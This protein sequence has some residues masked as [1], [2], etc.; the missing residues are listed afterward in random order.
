MCIDY[1]QPKK[2]T[3][4][5]KY[6]LPR[7]DDWF[8]QLQGDK[9]FSKIDLRLGYHQVQVWEKDILKIAFRT[10]YGHFEFLVM[11]FGL[12]NA[13]VVF[14]DLNNRIFRPSLDMFVITFIDD[15]LV[16]SRHIVS[17]TGIMVDTQNIEV[18]KTCPRPTTPSQHTFEEL[19][20]RFTSA[21][22][23]VLIEGYAVYC[24]TS[25][26]QQQI[27][28]KAHHSYYSI[29]PGLTKM[30]HDIKEIYWWHEMKRDIGEFVAHCPN[31]Q[32]VKVEH[33]KP[34]GLVQEIPIPVRKW[35]AINMDFITGL[36]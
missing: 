20:D 27:M 9:Y 4:K 24:D 13:P 26:L 25:R 36:P 21:P 16:Y 18:V 8:D 12:N 3:I 14:M 31:C 15:I 2:A 32:R 7:I 33:Q 23:L 17:D 28:A 5:N 11:S 1:R 6:P 10:R 22:F 34:A 35:E 30:Y 29:H 19:K